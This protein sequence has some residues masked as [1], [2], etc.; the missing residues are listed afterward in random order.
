MWVTAGGAVTVP[1]G[2]ERVYV[3]CAAAVTLTLPTGDCLVADRG[4]HA[5]TYAITCQ[6][7]PGGGT[8]DGNPNFV[9]VG[10]WAAQSFFWDGAN[11]GTA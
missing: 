7:P 10:D 5:G 9:L 8:I 3:N 2:V 1:V 6:P 4:P 11:F